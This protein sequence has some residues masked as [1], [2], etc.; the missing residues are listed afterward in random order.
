MEILSRP[1]TIEEM[2]ERQ[3]SEGFI[4]AIVAVNFN[5]V[6][7]NDQEYFLDL[8]SE[9]VTGKTTLQMVNY[10]LVGHQNGITVLLEVSGDVSRILDEHEEYGE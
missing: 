9:K 2:K 7:V 8:L 3:N 5:D 1:L 6:V 4:T 10:N